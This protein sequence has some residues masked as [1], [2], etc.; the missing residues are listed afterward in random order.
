MFAVPLVLVPQVHE[1][2]YLLIRDDLSRAFLLHYAQQYRHLASSRQRLAA[3]SWGGRTGLCGVHQACRA[4]G[5]AA[6]GVARKAS[7]CSAE[8]APSLAAT[9]PSRR[10]RVQSALD[11]CPLLVRSRPLRRMCRWPRSGAA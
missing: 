7:L 4:A 6:C 1:V 11:H 5:N 2:P 10:P 9:H 3:V 8:R